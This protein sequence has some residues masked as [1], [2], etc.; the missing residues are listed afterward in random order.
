MHISCKRPEPLSPPL[1]SGGGNEARSVPGRSR[2]RAGTKWVVVAALLIFVHAG[3][4][5]EAKAVKIH[6]EVGVASYSWKEFIAAEILKESGAIGTLSGFWTSTPRHIPP[7]WVLR[8]QMEVFLGRVN[9]QTGTI[10]SDGS[11][12]PSMTRT[13]YLGVD[14]AADLGRIFRSDPRILEPFLGLGSRLWV[15]DILSTEVALGYPEYYQTLYGRAGVRVT[16]PLNG[17]RTVE[18]TGV[19]EPML[20]ARE[21]V[22]LSH[23]S[24]ETL[25]LR[26]GR[27]NGWMLQLKS[28]WYG[29]HLSVYWKAVRLGRSNAV[30]CE[31]GLSLCVQPRSH[32]D[33]VGFRVGFPF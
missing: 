4:G 23:V 6:T 29:G 15:R 31:G 25:D 17:N 28:G 22:D 24:A 20:W 19:L 26:N 27:E 30:S 3:S 1:C 8:S 13:R 14:A 10:E 9:Y 32:Q 11:F 5:M 33:V 2:H 21:T 7:P 16:I 12:K 18:L